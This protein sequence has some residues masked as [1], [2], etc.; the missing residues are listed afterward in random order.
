MENHCLL[1]L[2]LHMFP[3]EN[4][5]IYLSAI[6]YA[7][8]ENLPFCFAGYHLVPE[9]FYSAVGPFKTS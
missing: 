5:D 8:L 1:T 6:R 7:V 2:Q 4:K 9:A 3:S